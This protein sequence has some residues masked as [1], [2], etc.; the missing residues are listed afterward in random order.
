MCVRVFVCVCVRVRGM[1]SSHGTGDALRGSTLVLSTAGGLAAAN[2]G[3]LCSKHLTR[4]PDGDEY[5]GAG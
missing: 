3:L 1:H 4:R 5:S 2:R